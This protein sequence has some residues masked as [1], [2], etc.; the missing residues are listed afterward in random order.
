[1]F[2]FDVAFKMK[3]WFKSLIESNKNYRLFSRQNKS[4]FIR[5]DSCQLN[6]MEMHNDLNS[7]YIL[8]LKTP[9]DMD[10]DLI[11][12]DNETPQRRTYLEQG[13]QNLREIMFFCEEKYKCLQQSL[14]NFYAWSADTSSSS[15]GNC[16][17]CQHRNIER[18]DLFN[19]TGDAI[20]MLKIVK[21][22]IEELE[23]DN[24]IFRDD[25]IGV[26]LQLKNKKLIKN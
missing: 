17:N 21:E 5:D 19:V 26:F 4:V 11:N 9:K 23:D 7:P 2:I 6:V 13:L 24:N 8:W 1:M 20:R 22:L 15:C 14:L 10:P 18:P 16:S 3:T 12:E 25:I